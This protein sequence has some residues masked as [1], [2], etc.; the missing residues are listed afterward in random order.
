LEGEASRNVELMWVTG[1]LLADHKPIANIRNDNG[2][3][4]VDGG[5]TAGCQ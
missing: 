4:P 3:L 2:H 5:G 1:R